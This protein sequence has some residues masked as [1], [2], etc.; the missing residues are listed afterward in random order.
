MY[1]IEINRLLQGDSSIL[2]NEEF[3]SKI[4]NDITSLMNMNSYT[5]EQ[6]DIIG[7]LLHIGNI[8]YNNID[9]DDSNQIID[10]DTY[11]ILLEKYRVYNPNVQV[12]AEPVYFAPI[13]SNQYENHDQ[14]I[15]WHD[16]LD[17]ETSLFKED[18]YDP[19]V[20]GLSPQPFINYKGNITNKKY[21][22][23]A[24]GNNELVGTLDKCK[25]VLISQA[26]EKGCLDDPS[27]KVLERDFFLNHIR[28]GI[29]DYNTIFSMILELKYDGLS[30]VVT[31]KNKMVVYAVSRGDTGADKATDLTPILYGYPFPNLPENIELDIKCEAVMTRT[32]L[33]YYNRERNKDYKNC[34][35]AIIGLFSSNEGALYRD[36]ITLVPLAVAPSSLSGKGTELDTLDRIT[37]VEFIN[38]YLVTK[39]FLRNAVITGNYN[40]I[41]FL[42]KKFTDEAELIRPL[43]PTM[44]DGIVVSYCDDNIR[45]ILGRENFVNK[46]SIAVKFNTMKKLTEL[47]SISYT[48]GQDGTITPMAHYKPVTFIG[49]VHTKSSLASLARFNENKFKIG[50]I[51]EVEYRND[52]MPYVTTPELDHNRDNPN[53]VLEFISYCPACGT[54]LVISK[55]G[56]SAKCP[57]TNCKGRSIARMA[58]MMDKL[59]LKDFAEASVEKINKYHLVD[60]I[61]M[62]VDQLI[63]IIGEVNAHKFVDRMNELKSKDIYDFEIVGALGFS[64]IAQE[65]WK[66]IFSNISLQQL[67]QYYKSNEL[68]KILSNIK[69]IGPMTIQTIIDE[70]EFFSYDLDYIV[71]MPNVKS[72]VGLKQKTIRVTGFRNPE[73]ME[74]LK[75]LGYDA[76]DKS[77]TKSTD[78]LLVPNEEFTSSKL[79]KVGPNTLIIP[80]REFID[81][82]QYYL[83]KI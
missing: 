62:N 68:E 61:D 83:S 82:M 81:N 48:V 35:S 44:Y 52:V 25:Y 58:N 19:V 80:V 46:Y 8:V 31:V 57:N 26:E 77:V 3:R 73:L 45:R 22:T 5:K 63:D 64:G 10:N 36:Y 54:K 28:A 51:I 37:E 9:L 71:N 30:V 1:E 16:T 29:I 66:K 43:M 72:S 7:E 47:L 41:L 78:I 70:M 69:G 12:G 23:V 4:N 17:E 56:K 20:S 67:L 59:G 6:Y 24:H 53:P 60:I 14:F 55:S 18:I 79:S 75:T 42:I 32:D 39:E 74:Q 76:S 13:Q 38:K 15:I 2:F 34:R 49:T 27:V 11:D 65:T 21:R 40:T 50:N 33:A